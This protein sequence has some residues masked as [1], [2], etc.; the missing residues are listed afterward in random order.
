[1]TPLEQLRY[2]ERYLAQR[3]FQGRLGTLEGVYTAV[4]SG[5]A[6]SDGDEVVFGPGRNYNANSQ[7]DWNRDGQITAAEAT[8]PV[9][10]RLFGGVTR[11]QTRLR[12]LGYYDRKPDGQYGPL[13]RAA[14]ERF[15]REHQLPVTGRR[16]VQSLLLR[17]GP[18]GSMTPRALPLRPD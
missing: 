6:R 9:A 18:Q 12:E 7:L 14:L 8:N 13:T 1:M 4:L 2:V 11:V 5:R 15:Q 3:K 16:P 17:P 10:F